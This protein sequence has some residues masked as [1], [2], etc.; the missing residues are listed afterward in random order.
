MQTYLG[1][2]R[3]TYLRRHCLSENDLQQIY[4]LCSLALDIQVKA[5]YITLSNGITV[6]HTLNAGPNGQEFLCHCEKKI[7]TARKY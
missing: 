6:L 4:I 1:P 2:Y 7:S 5:M 3:P